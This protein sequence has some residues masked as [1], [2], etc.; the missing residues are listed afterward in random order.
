[1]EDKIYIYGS[2]KIGIFDLNGEL[3]MEIKRSFAMSNSFWRMEIQFVK[4]GTSIE[5]K[6]ENSPSYRV[7]NIVIV[8]SKRFQCWRKGI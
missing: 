8:V 2:G 7:S 4:I 1:M 6:V 3:L 5:A